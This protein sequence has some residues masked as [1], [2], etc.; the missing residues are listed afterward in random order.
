MPYIVEEI[1]KRN[2]VFSD[3]EMDKLDFCATDQQQSLKITL[4]KFDDQIKESKRQISPSRHKKF[5]V[6]YIRWNQ[7]FRAGQ[8]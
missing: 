5:T 1:S 3:E 8:P 6:D 2:A 4:K 7:L